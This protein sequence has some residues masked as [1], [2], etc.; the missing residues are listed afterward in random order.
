MS[1]QVE[2][3]SLLHAYIQAAFVAVTMG[4]SLSH[5]FEYYVKPDLPADL[6]TMTPEECAVVVQMQ[7]A[8]VIR[9]KA[10]RE[11]S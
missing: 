4:V 3:K 7:E 10:E 1:Q 8:G 6:P 2:T 9:R 11:A 5:A